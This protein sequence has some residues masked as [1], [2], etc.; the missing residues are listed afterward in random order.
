MLT[1][2]DRYLREYRAKLLQHKLEQRM[3]H[4]CSSG[5][6]FEH[7]YDEEHLREMQTALWQTRLASVRIVQAMRQ[8]V[9]DT[10]REMEGQ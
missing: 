6:C 5:L 4:T 2:Y 3:E 9:K 8:A 1:T 10:M 7:W